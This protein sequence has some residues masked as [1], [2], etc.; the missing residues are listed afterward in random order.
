MNITSS[1]VKIPSGNFAFFIKEYR[2]KLLET[3]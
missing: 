1:P 3:D 2:K